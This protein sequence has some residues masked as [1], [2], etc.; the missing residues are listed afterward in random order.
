M[1]REYINM[2]NYKRSMPKVKVEKTTD[3]KPKEVEPIIEVPFI[4]ETP[5]EIVDSEIKVTD[6]LIGGQ[7]K[8]LK[9]IFKEGKTQLIVGINAG[10]RMYGGVIM[11]KPIDIPGSSFLISIDKETNDKETKKRTGVCTFLYELSPSNNTDLEIS[12]L[13]ELVKW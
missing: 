5:F 1:K 9:S 4:S 3:E 10:K 8:I 12:Q 11:G 13:E 7:L 6:Y 2:E